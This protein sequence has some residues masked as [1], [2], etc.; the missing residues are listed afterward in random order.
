MSF[1]R[2]RFE[3]DEEG[4]KDTDTLE[5]PQSK[6]LDR[7]RQVEFIAHRVRR[8]EAGVSARRGYVD[9]DIKITFLSNTRQGSD[10]SKLVVLDP[11]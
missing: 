9:A 6:S 10:A 2:V 1:V 4:R 11:G 5:D 7:R 3:L 8:R